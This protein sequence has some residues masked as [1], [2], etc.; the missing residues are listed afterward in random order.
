M[1]ITKTKFLE[2]S[3]PSA[4]IINTSTVYTKAEGQGLLQEYS[5]LVASDTF[6][7]IFRRL[8]C[9]N[10]GSWSEATP[11]FAPRETPAGIERQ[12][13]MALLHD[14][15]TERLLRIY[16][17]HL[18]PGGNHT[19]EVMGLTTICYEISCDGGVSF[20]APRQLIVEGMDAEAWAPKVKYG[21][22]SMM[23]SFSAPFV[24]RRGRLMVPA[25][26]IRYTPEIASTYR[27]P[28][29]AGCFIGEWD[30]TGNLRWTLGETVCTDLGRSSRGLYEPAI[31]ELSDGRFLMIC[32]GSNAGLEGVPSRKWKAISH[33]GALTWSSPEPW[34]DDEGSLFFSPS[35]GSIL[36]RHSRNGKLYWLGNITPENPGGNWPRYPLVIAEVDDTNVCLIQS[37]LQTIDTRL[38]EDGEALQLSNF[39]AYEDRFTGELVVMVARLGENA[40]DGLN[41]PAYQYRIA[42]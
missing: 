34:S 9:D 26:L 5:E 21:E 36:I 24:D 20:S 3:R 41:T 37:S 14:P 16:N 30:A 1:V 15:H 18:Y 33:D 32:R 31:A 6:G 17:Q 10:G 23:V 13:E 4:A 38:P 22:N 19:R 2:S 12:G 29:E 40:E 35:S 8:S 11:V 25:Q 7:A 39:K 28:L 27:I 42:V